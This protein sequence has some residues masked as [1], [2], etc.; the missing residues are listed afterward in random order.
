M[1]KQYDRITDKQQVLIESSPLFFVA[2]VHPELSDAPSGAG[3][4]NVSPKGGTRL[5]VLDPQRVAYLDYPGSGNETARHAEAG[6]PVTVLAMSFG[7]EDAAIVR[8]YGKATILP[9]E[10]DHPA[11]ATLAPELAK[12]PRQIVEVEVL[13]TQT[14]CGYGVPIL[15][16]VGE[17]TRAGRGRR[18]KEPKPAQS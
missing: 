8:L 12:K 4:V 17:R 10:G 5:H 16:Y 6:G 11:L 3:P 15:D 7:A 14:S 2:G 9:A 18:F 1:G 13:K